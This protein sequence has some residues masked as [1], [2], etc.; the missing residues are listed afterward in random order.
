MPKLA[1]Y[2]G[3]HLYILFPVGLGEHIMFLSVHC[4]LGMVMVPGNGKWKF[5]EQ[6]QHMGGTE[7]ICLESREKGILRI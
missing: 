7:K 4:S 6:L 3:F 5:V 2:F 1:L